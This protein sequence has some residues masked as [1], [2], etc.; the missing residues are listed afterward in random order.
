MVISTDKVDRA[1]QIRSGISNDE[2]LLKRRRELV[3]K[4]SEVFLKKGFDRTTVSELAKAMNMAVGGLYRYIGSK[5][6][7]L[8][9]ILEYMTIRTN[10]INNL[11]PVTDHLPSIEAL[12]MGIDIHY[13]AIDELKNMYNFLNHVMV[14]LPPET[15]RKLGGADIIL[16]EYFENIIQRGK[17]LGVFEVEDPSYV[18]YLIMLA[19]HGWANRH[20][21]LKRK[22]TIE[23]YIKITTDN[24][25]KQLL[26]PKQGSN[27]VKETV[28]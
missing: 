18:A 11:I 14:N 26:V 15:R 2:L 28:I 6:D 12:K 16:T 8:T 5:E 4:S 24:I 21:F 9:L 7:I 17:D 13:K 27:P 20:W 19:G 23:Q 10:G 22:Y 25:L 3:L 1:K